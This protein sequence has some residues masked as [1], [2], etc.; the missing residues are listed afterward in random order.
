MVRATIHDHEP[1]ERSMAATAEAGDQV[2]SLRSWI[3][4]SKPAALGEA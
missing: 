3:E 1:R 4:S 2:V